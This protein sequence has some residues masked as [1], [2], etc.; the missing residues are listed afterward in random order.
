MSKFVFDERLHALLEAPI[1]GADAPSLEQIE[2]TLT[3]GYA[4]ALALEGERKR[5][6]RRIGELAAD[7][8]GDAEEKT[9]ELTLLSRRLA[10]AEAEL[11]GLRRTLVDVRRRA[12]AWRAAHASVA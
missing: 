6:A 11:A 1:A 2:T 3:D 7:E 4:T 5:L 9:R 8:A 10:D 12:A